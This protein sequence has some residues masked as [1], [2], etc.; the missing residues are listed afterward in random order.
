MKSLLVGINSK[1][2]HSCLAVRYLKACCPNMQMKEYTINERAEDVTADIYRQQADNVLFSCYVWN[3]DFVLEIAQRLSKVSHCKIILG[4]PEVTYNAAEVMQKY[5]FIDAVVV[6]EG[7]KTVL[8]LEK[9]NMSPVGV[10]GVV[11]R[12]GGNI[13]ENEPRALIADFDSIPFPYTDDDIKNL[14]GKLVYYESSRGCPFRCSYCLSSTLHGVR[15][16][17]I[18]LV[19]KELMFFVRNK[20]RIV[21]FVDRTFNADK[22]RT[23]ELLRFLIANASE[24]TFHFEIAADLINDEMLEILKSAPK[25]LFQLEIGV[26]STNEKTLR[27]IDRYADNEKIKSNVRKVMRLGTVHIHLDLIAGL[28]Y[29]DFNSFKRSFDEV[30]ALRAD[31]LQLGFLKLLPGTKIRAEEKLF[32]YKFSDKAP[33]EVLCNDFISYDDILA[34]KKTENVLER[35]CNSGVFEK[36][37][38]C[39]FEKY[40]SAFEMLFELAEFFEK[41]G[42]DKAAHSQKT[43]YAILAEFYTEHY[44]DARFYDCLKYDYFKYNK[45]ASYPEWAIVGYDKALLK[46]RFEFLTEENIEKYL[47][48]YAG[49]APKEIVKSVCFEEFCYDVLGDGQKRENIIIFD[50][51]YGKNVR[52]EKNSENR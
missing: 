15:F 2:I 23:Y 30:F 14:D 34:L 26:Q 31:V 20:V 28:P 37:L 39:L 5:E 16:R 13:I 35:Y 24:T 8:E 41:K 40:D 45:G 25:G 9:N 44:C 38:D 3:I 29:E 48:E 17:S 21:K 47:P 18:E 42:Y 46:Y 4:G 19:K 22:K 6:G 7:E 49:Q 12:S 36:S 50:Y 43:L 1:Y 27:A 51:G 33:Y 32:N 11:Y 52:I 10:D